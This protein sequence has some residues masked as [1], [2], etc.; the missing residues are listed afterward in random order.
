M[1]KDRWALVTGASAGI[2]E[3]YA[4]ALMEKGANLIL[5]ARRED[6]LK[7]LAESVEA[8]GQRALIVPTDLS[9][10]GAPETIMAQVNA[11]GVPVDIL[12][13]NAGYGLPGT[14]SETTWKDQQ[15]F[16][17]VMVTAYAQLTHLALGPMRERGWGRIINVASLAG[18]IPAGANYTLYGASK[19]FVIAMTQSVAAECRGTDI[20]ASACCPGFTYSEFH[21]VTET[22]EV[23]NKLPKYA[24]MEAGPVAELS[25]RAVEKGHTTYVPGGFN[26]FIAALLRLLPLS[27]AER[28][29]DRHSGWK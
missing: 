26:K 15:D 3:A 22:R 19:A 6:R 7:A 13:N 14:Y 5:V 10:P 18:L 21:D 9:D 25:L 8:K 23:V 17:Q 27:I 4:N 11:A 29:V 16:I 20:K 24:F 1:Y 2:G 12:V 28:L